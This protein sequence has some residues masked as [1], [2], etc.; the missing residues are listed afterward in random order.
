MRVDLSFKEEVRK[1][2]GQRFD[3]CFQCLSCA[4][5]CPVVE[6]MDYN[7]TQIVRL[8]EFGQRERVLASKAIWVC[9]GCHACVSQCPNRVNVPLLMDTLRQMALEQGVEVPEK[10]IVLFHRTFLD[11]VRR[12]G[13]IY[14]LG[15]AARY[16]LASWTLFQDLIAGLKFLWKRKFKFLPEAVKGLSDIRTI[17]REGDGK[18]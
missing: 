11:Q 9:V 3:A 6:D 10:R 1:R 2:S 14:E 4:G 12:R 7:P 5:G 18:A 13:R 15:L 17:W 16:K 8:V